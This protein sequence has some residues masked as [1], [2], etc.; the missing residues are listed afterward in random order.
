MDVD[1]DNN[2]PAYS[3]SKSTG[4]KLWLRESEGLYVLDMLV[5]PSEPA[6]LPV[7]PVVP[8][9]DLGFSGRDNS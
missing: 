5:V 1:D 8:S 2:R 6:A 3:E 4:E 9:P 7:R